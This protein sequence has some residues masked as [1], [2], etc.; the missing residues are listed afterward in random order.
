MRTGFLIL[1]FTSL[2][3]LVLGQTSDSDSIPEHPYR[4]S[5][6]FSA[7]IP[8][9]VQVYNSVLKKKGFRHAIWKVP[10]IYGALGASTYMLIQNQKTQNSLKNH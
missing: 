10:L 3:I 7:I 5:I 1:Y 6:M 4:K 9:G 8:G 2:S